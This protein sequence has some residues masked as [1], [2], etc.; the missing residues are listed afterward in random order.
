MDLVAVGYILMAA[1]ALGIL[2]SLFLN[3]QRNENRRATCRRL[4]DRLTYEE[5]RRGQC[6]HDP[7]HEIANPVDKPVAMI[8]RV[9]ALIDAAGCIAMDAS[10]NT[11]ARFSLPTCSCSNVS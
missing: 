11:V 3:A 8:P 4:A 1:G 6:E 2:L 5:Q 9:I 7:A 10:D